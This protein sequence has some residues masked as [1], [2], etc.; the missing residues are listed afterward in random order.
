M[1]AGR[2]GDLVGGERI[3]ARQD[4]RI[5][6]TRADEIDEGPVSGAIDDRIRPV[7]LTGGDQVVPGVERPSADALALGERRVRV[8]ATR[9]FS[10]RRSTLDASAPHFCRS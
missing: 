3:E 4:D 9:S 6:G 2:I 7:V 5:G 1:V 8:A 10:P